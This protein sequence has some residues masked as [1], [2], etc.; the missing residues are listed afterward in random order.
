MT[1]TGKLPETTA[2]RQAIRNTFQSATKIENLIEINNW[3]SG[4]FGCFIVPKKETELTFFGH[5]V[6][7][8]EF[9]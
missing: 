4:N 5:Y 6:K 1:N 8:S 9:S 7:F 2:S 3:L